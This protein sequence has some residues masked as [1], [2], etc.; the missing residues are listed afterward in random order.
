MPT[1]NGANAS[2]GKP[3]TTATTLALVDT[4][5][6]TRNHDFGGTSSHGGHGGQ[7]ADIHLAAVQELAVAAAVAVEEEAAVAAAAVVVVA[8]KFKL[9]L[10]KT[11]TNSFFS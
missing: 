11:L 2:F 1:G 10:I 4:T 5:A 9:Q 8:R 3:A 7:I 6:D